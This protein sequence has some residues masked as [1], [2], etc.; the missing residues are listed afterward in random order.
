MPEIERIWRNCRWREGLA[1]RL[2]Q[3]LSTMLIDR[4]Q[5]G[6]FHDAVWTDS[7]AAFVLPDLLERARPTRLLRVWSPA[8]ANGEELYSV[9]LLL[10]AALPDADDWSIFLTGTD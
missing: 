2:L 4:A 10:A 7:L 1:R 9:S 3:A 6:F 8:C 5:S